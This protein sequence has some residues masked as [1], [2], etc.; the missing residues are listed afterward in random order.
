[1]AHHE[2]GRHRNPLVSIVRGTSSE[3]PFIDILLLNPRITLVP[4]RY[5]GQQ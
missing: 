5:H 3:S 4:H 2:D 1:M